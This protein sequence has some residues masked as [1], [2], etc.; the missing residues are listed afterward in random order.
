MSIW[1]RSKPATERRTEWPARPLSEVLL[2]MV[3]S[4]FGEIDLSSAESAMQSIAI[5]STVDLIASLGSELPA[6]VYRGEGSTRQKLRM[7]DHLEDPDGSGHGL[8]DWSYRALYTWLL[9]GN[10]YGDV[11]ERGPGGMLRQVE[12]FHP[13]KVDAAIEGD[14]GIVWHVQGQEIPT[15]RLLHRRVNPVPGHVL[16]MSPISM[17]AWNIGLSLTTT[18]FGLQWFQDGAHPGGILSN[19]EESINKDKAQTVK[20]RFLAAVRGTREPV[21]MGKGWTYE[22]IQVNPEESQFLETQGFSAAECARIFGP[23]F[24]E[25]LGYVTKGGSMTYANV[26]DRD[27]HVLKYGLNKWLRRLERLLSEFLPRPQYVKINRDALLETNTFQRYQA[28]ALALGGKPWKVPNE[29]RDKEELPPVPWGEDP[30]PL[31]TATPAIEPGD[32]DMP[33]KPD[34]D[35]ED[36]E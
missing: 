11:L 9:R 13:D 5:R 33:A 23:G 18:R 8:A 17:H 7:P 10:L 22:Q 4:G 26:V 14:G 21:V 27:L 20:E 3:R 35:Q 24:A 16:G 19:S 1:F 2:G 31:G 36:D 25:I 29:V 28:H 12:L 32:P 6:D 34:D 15:S 30:D